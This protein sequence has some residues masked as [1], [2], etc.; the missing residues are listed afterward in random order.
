MWGRKWIDHMMDIWETFS[1]CGE[2]GEKKANG[3][4][5]DEGIG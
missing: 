4:R 1:G 3:P 5:K 2:W